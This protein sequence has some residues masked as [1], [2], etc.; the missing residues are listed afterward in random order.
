MQITTFMGICVYVYKWVLYKF[1]CS[2]Q[3]IC[4]RGVRCCCGKYGILLDDRWWSPNWTDCS[5]EAWDL[6]FF[7]R[8]A[9]GNKWKYRWPAKRYFMYKINKCTPD[10]T[11]GTNL[12]SCALKLLDQKCWEWTSIWV[13]SALIIWYSAPFYRYKTVT[14][15]LSQ[16]WLSQFYT[17]NVLFLNKV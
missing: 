10:L 16:N 17:Y 7:S 13:S 15:C 12:A 3:Y 14:I 4:L 1:R 8:V 5:D 11:N 6:S 9:P 2:L